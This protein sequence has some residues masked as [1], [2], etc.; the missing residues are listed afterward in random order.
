MI[1]GIIAMSMNMI[2]N[3]ILIKHMKIA[4]IAFSTS[5]SSIV[6]VLLLF[7]SLK[8]KIGYY[9]QDKILS[10]TFKSSIAALVMG[11]VVYFTYNFLNGMPDVGFVN[12]VISLFGTI[13]IGAVVY[14]IMIIILKVEEIN[15]IKDI[16]KSKSKK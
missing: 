12:E 14:S 7:R 9:G 15:M 6:C 2:L 4:G 13:G 11:V 5:L 1:N 10:T 8:K 16:L 3:I